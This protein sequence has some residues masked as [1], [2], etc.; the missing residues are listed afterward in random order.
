MPVQNTAA[1]KVGYV[2]LGITYLASFILSIIACLNKDRLMYPIFKGLVMPSIMIFAHFSWNGSY[3]RG[4]VL[5]QLAFLFAWLGD[6]MLAL[7]VAYSFQFFIGGWLFFFQHVLYIWLNVSA[8]NSKDSLWKV[9]C[10]GLPLLAYAALFGI[11]YLARGGVI[12][13]IQFTGYSI[14]LSTSFYTSFYRECRS[15][16][17]YVVCIIGFAF[18]I[19]SDIFLMLGRLVVTMKSVQSFLVLLTYYIAQSLICYSHV[20]ESKAIKITS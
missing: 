4:Y 11:T 19:I 8:K 3:N 13:K 10:R 1:T 18:F 5:L 12:A 2:F 6:V 17:M 15:K 16:S 20:E 14:A 7:P 9:P